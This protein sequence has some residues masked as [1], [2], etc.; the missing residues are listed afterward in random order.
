MTQYDC[1]FVN[2]DSYSQS[3]KDIKVYADFLG[4]FFNIPV[5]NYAAAGSNNDRILRSSI[6]YL[7]KLKTE[8]KNPLVI[9]GWSF[10]HRFEVWENRDNIGG[11]EWIPDKKYFPE[12]RFVTLEFLLRANSAT[13]EQKSLINLD[14]CVHKPFMDFYRNLY[15][16][17]HFLESLNFDYLFFSAADNEILGPYPV[18]DS[19]AQVQWVKNN[20]KI[21]NL[22]SFF[23][24][25]WAKLN[26][27]D[28]DPITGHLSESGHE[29][30]AAVLLN[31]VKEQYGNI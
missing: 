18:F 16:F 8:Y 5:K 24:K 3:P 28:C 6:E 29:K 19:Y 15:L 23:V 10:V 26:D 11:L 12:S 31:I 14:P 7:E 2:G 21:Y 22:D 13:L 1:I 4:D 25:K 27:P 17:A 30:F 9:I 20:K